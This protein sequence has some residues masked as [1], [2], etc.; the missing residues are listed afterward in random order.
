VLITGYREH[1]WLSEAGEFEALS[2]ETLEARLR[3]GAVPLVCHAPMTRRRAGLGPFA[4]FDL[5]ELFAFVRPAQALVPTARGLAQ[6]FDF[7]L[8]EDQ[9]DALLLLPQVAALLL[10]ETRRWGEKARK[11]AL[12]GI[13][14]AQQRRWPWAE[15]LLAALGP[16]EPPL[17]PI[18]ALEIWRRLPAWEDIAPA[19]KPGTEPVLEAEA[20]AQLDA[21]LSKHRASEARPQQRRYAEAASWA[22]RPADAPGTPQVVLAEAGT[23][24]GKTLGYLAPAA[25]WQRKNQGPVWISTYTRNLQRQLDQELQYLYPNAAE[26]DARVV[27]RKGRENY[28]CLL[29]Y[30]EAVQALRL[31]GQ[32]DAVQ[33]MLI[34]RWAE[35]SRAGELVGGDLPGWLADLAGSRWLHS[36]ADQRGECGYAACP[37][38][39]RCFSER[40]QRQARH[41]DLVIANHALTL[42]QLASGPRFGEALPVHWVFDEGHQLFDAADSAF[43]AV[44]SGQEGRD[45]RRW[46]LGVENRTAAGSGRARGLRMRLSDL[47]STLTSTLPGGSS[48][49]WRQLDEALAQSERAAALLPASGW[50]QRLASGN[51]TGSYEVFLAAVATQV[52]ARNSDAQRQ[53]YSIEC[54]TQPLLPQVRDAAQALMADLDRLREPLLALYERL[55]SV[56]L[57]EEID[58][59]SSDP[60]DESLQR[61]PL[62]TEA[63]RRLMALQ[64]SLERRALMPL[65]AWSAMLANL[66]S[67]TDSLTESAAEPSSTLTSEPSPEVEKAA[68][69]DWFAIER[70]DGRDA[71]VTFC[72]HRLDPLAPLF[73]LLRAHTQGVLITSATLTDPRTPQ[74]VAAD[75]SDA[76]ENLQET[77]PSDFGDFSD[78]SDYARHL[79]KAPHSLRIAS[80][81]NYKAQAQVFVVTDVPKNQPRRVASAFVQLFKAS[82]G[83]ALGLFTA[84]QRLRALHPLIA[85]RLEA[86]G[87]PL[88]AQHVDAADPTTLVDMFRTELDSCLLGT[89]AMRDGVDVPGLALRLV[90]FERVPWPRPDILH[91]A[92]RNAAKIDDFDDR[93][94]RLRLKQAFGRL[95][96]HGEDRGAF[97]MLDGQTPSRLLTAFP[98]EVAPQ[99]AS[100]AEVCAALKTLRP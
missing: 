38:Y 55:D 60:S 30:E 74:A 25:V 36:L 91:R 71:D 27:V 51:A 95:I 57:E 98:P 8:P 37:H 59:P 48:N 42:T 13:F 86:A 87:I 44:L 26:Q 14:L 31:A 18:E 19:G 67:V 20:S 76:V 10:D 94:A 47:P 41:A 4:C 82:G 92:R 3:E 69:I 90:V 49:L 1:A 24:V 75:D 22:F 50:R 9:E 53:P 100:L 81:F 12:E 68:S 61:S 35:A 65:A 99:R 17:D 70:L 34:A 6:R 23:G 43:A 96:R 40:I 28:L 56:L 15:P 66:D 33:L 62:S 88:Y 39:G 79:G 85:A 73:G 45:L 54:P 93:K 83:G 7:A 64:Q 80:P 5:L 89:D 32:V 11:R 78:F 77:E 84:V 29:N 97:V 2:S 58:A 63:R 16:A 21:L 72:R 52:Y 46:L